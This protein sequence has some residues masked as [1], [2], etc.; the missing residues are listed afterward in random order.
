MYLVLHLVSIFCLQLAGPSWW[1]PIGS[2]LFDG[3]IKNQ[4]LKKNTKTKQNK[5]RRNLTSFTFLKGEH[6]EIFEAPQGNDVKQVRKF[7]GQMRIQCEC[8]CD[9][10]FEAWG[11]ALYGSCHLSFPVC[12]RMR[13]K[14]RGGGGH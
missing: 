12:M 7:T 5:T 11:M 9:F 8:M 6:K 10:I 2:R 1:R 4:A 3:H 14:R 13:E